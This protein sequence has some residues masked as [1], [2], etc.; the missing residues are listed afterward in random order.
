MLVHVTGSP[1]G[2]GAINAA[3]VHVQRRYYQQ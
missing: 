2:D 1:G 3:R